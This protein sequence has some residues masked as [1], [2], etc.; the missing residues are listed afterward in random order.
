MDSVVHFEM[1]YANRDRMSRFYESAFGWHTQMLGDEMGN[2]VVAT[3][4]ETDERGPKQPGKI[5]GG[6]FPR[7]PDYAA[8]YP[9]VVIA[10]A[11]I[12]EFG[13]E[14][15][16]GGRQGARRTDGYTRRRPICLLHRHRGQSRQ[17]AQADSAQSTPLDD[18][19]TGAG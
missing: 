8:Q 2:S 9:S 10:V 19:I 6:F 5:N 3:T 1:P 13:Q 15:H 17:H 4:T 12:D 18:G 16:Q 7:K 11:D 14:S